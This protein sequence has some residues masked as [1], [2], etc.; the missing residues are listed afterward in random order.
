[1]SLFY[2]PSLPLARLISAPYCVEEAQ[3]GVLLRLLSLVP[4]ENVESLVIGFSNI[5]DAG[6]QHVSQM[7]GLRF[8]TV[9]RTQVGDAGVAALSALPHLEALKLTGCPVT[10]A[11]LSH[12]AKMK[13]LRYLKL[14]YA[15]VTDAGLTQLA[16]LDGLHRLIVAGSKITP[17]GVEKLRRALPKCEVQL[18]KPSD[19]CVSVQTAT[20]LAGN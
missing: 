4:L 5:G 8:L 9:Q 14:T 20:V 19:G 2:P 16:Q 17:A 12:V 18:L 13:T 6:M 7:H 11:G 1:M 15:D 3:S 10:D